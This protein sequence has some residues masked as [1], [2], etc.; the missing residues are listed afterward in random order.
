MHRRVS[1]STTCVHL[2]TRASNPRST[3]DS[4]LGSFLSSELESASQSG[5]HTTHTVT[6]PGLLLLVAVLAA[7]RV[8]SG[9]SFGALLGSVVHNCM[10]VIRAGGSHAGSR[11]NFRPR[12][13]LR[14][15][16]Y[17]QCCEPE[18][19]WARFQLYNCVPRSAVQV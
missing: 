6:L 19:R 7:P 10:R 15:H 17:C 11:L 16:L 13:L 8:P 3:T 14:V 18:S 2:P 5:V 1:L 4:P 12:T 9:V